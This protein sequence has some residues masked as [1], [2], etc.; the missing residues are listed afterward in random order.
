MIV[1]TAGDRFGLVVDEL[2]QIFS[3]NS[4]DKFALPE[5]LLSSNDRRLSQD[6][7]EIVLICDQKRDVQ[8]KLVVLDVKKILSRVTGLP[9]PEVA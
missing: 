5:L 6:M 3:V 8:T 1:E 2:E 7:K 9:I 4:A